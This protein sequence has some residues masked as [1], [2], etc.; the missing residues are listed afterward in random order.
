VMKPLMAVVALVLGMAVYA[1]LPAAAQGADEK[2]AAGLAERIQDLNLTDQQEAKVADIRKEF[3]PKVQEA[4]KD[5]AAVVKEEVEKVHGVLTPEQRKKLEEAKDE[6][7]ELRAE[8]L[9][10][11]LAHLEELDL[12]DAE[13]A[14]IMEI[15][16]EFRPKIE[17]VMKELEG[18]LTDQQKKAREEGLKAGMKRREVIA[19]LKLTADQKAKVEAVSKEVRT[20][21]R[22]ELE[23]MRDILAEG[24]T[25]KL[26]EFKEE[27]GESVRDRKAHAIAN[28]K[29]LNL[30]EEQKTKIMEIRKEYRPKVH[31][32]GNK[33]RATVRE[34]VEAIVAVIKS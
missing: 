7:K 14:K 27:R 18:L 10:E 24:Q 20:L 15:R 3:K 28:L 33:L 16:K 17:K 30:T 29:E 9:P 12:T 26:Q 31:E 11:R 34:E 5:L 21:V 6:R 13:A 22:E 25:E 2:A 1:A 8:R 23:K 4:A 19:S 32:A